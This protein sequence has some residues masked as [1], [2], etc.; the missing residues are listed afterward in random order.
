MPIE[1]VLRVTED[2]TEVFSVMCNLGVGASSDLMRNLNELL[3]SGGSNR[4][5]L[6]NIAGYLYDVYPGSH[7]TIKLERWDGY[8]SWLR[9]D[10]PELAAKE[11]S[12]PVIPEP[13]ERVSRY[14]RKPVI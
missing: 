14:N 3:D 2:D 7:W 12:R 5:I 6:M 4:M 10:G 1:V 9:F 13:S 11:T 8:V